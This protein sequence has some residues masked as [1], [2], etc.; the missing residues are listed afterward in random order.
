MT[1]M[2]NSGR[3]F[4][5]GGKLMR[6][7]FKIVVVLCALFWGGAAASAQTDNCD[8]VLINQIS[9]LRASDRH[10]ESWLRII[11]ENSYSAAKQKAGASIYS[12]WF[13][14]SYSNFNTKRNQ[15]FSQTGSTMSRETA[16]EE[17]KSYLS[18][19]QVQ[20]WVAC[21]GGAAGIAAHYRDVDSIGA[22]IVL[23]WQ[24]GSGIGPLRNVRFELI[25]VTKQ[26]EMSTTQLLGEESFLVERR[27]A[28]TPIRGKITGVAGWDNKNY[29]AT[30]YIPAYQVQTVV[31]PPL[32]IVTSVA[33]VIVKSTA[34]WGNG[35][36]SWNC[37][38]SNAE[39][40]LIVIGTQDRNIGR[41]RGRCVGQGSYCNS[42]NEYC[43]ETIATAGCYVSR[44]W[45]DWYK[46]QLE[47]IG[48]PYQRNRVC[49]P[50]VLT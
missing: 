2:I 22:T 5:T 15:Y 19:S 37:E 8:G 42:H 29:Q 34:R 6:P 49:D 21:K 14:G 20:A 9:Y 4:S 28:D 48:E 46:G 41:R 12:G 26:P 17:Y 32:K 43:F 36:R 45:L 24:A 11:D 50:T 3:K 13:S 10:S 31:R 33:N 27:S 18:E 1:Y 30:I 44:R 39:R 25:G 16:F 40:E 38:A 35:S 7:V 23:N 47:A